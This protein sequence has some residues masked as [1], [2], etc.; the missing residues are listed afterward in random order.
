[1][2]RPNK[3]SLKVRPRRMK[4]QVSK[5]TSNLFFFW[6]HVVA[7]LLPLGSFSGFIRH[8]DHLQFLLFQHTSVLF[9]LAVCL[10]G[11]QGKFTLPVTP[12]CCLPLVKK[13]ASKHFAMIP[14]PCFFLWQ[15]YDTPVN[16]HTF[17]SN[18]RYAPTVKGLNPDKQIHKNVFALYDWT[19]SVAN[20]RLRL[21]KLKR[22]TKKMDIH[23]KAK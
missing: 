3:T 16:N 21:E 4:T 6:A 11:W 8:S 12:L 19:R 13:E 2:E 5:V 9:T 20:Y 22:L 23:V 14:D 7:R 1:M 17:P 15:R 10:A 18:N